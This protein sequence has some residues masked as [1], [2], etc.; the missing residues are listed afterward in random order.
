MSKLTDMLQDRFK[1]VKQAQAIQTKIESEKREWTA[2][3]RS[4]YDK[5]FADV[6]GMKDKIDELQKDEERGKKV[7]KA[8]E[9]MEKPLKKGIVEDI[10]VED[11]KLGPYDTPEYRKFFSKYLVTGPEAR[12]EFRGLQMDLDAGGGY[13]VLPQQFVGELIEATKALCFFR[14]IAKIY[15]VT[16][17]ESLGLP[18]LVARP[19]APTWTSELSIGAFDTAM[20][21]GKREL[22]P[23]PLAQGVKISKKLLR[24][25]T[26]NTD[27]TVRDQLAYMCAITEENAFLNGNGAGQPLGVFVANSEGIDTNRD[28]ST[29]NTATAIT[30]DGLINCYFNL[31]PVYWAQAKWIFH[32]NAIRNLRKLRGNDGDYLW[33]AGLSNDRGDTLL[34]CPVLISEFAPSTFT[35]GKYVGI[36]GDFSRYV[37]A[38]ALDVTLQV[39]TELYAGSNENGYLLRKE[40]DGMPVIAEAFSR[41]TLA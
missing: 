19:S 5:I 13:T 12:S 41:L 23:H 15:T 32:P 28:I 1:L 18:A 37:I 6:D 21:Y 17:A 14:S 8:L 22:H 29:D 40:T 10:G 20:Q 33:K 4:Q 39:L 30:S 9:E 38:D 31:R 26:L 11:R 25:S 34:N 16:N 2:E 3:E 27:Q 36:L 35:T 7:T 24:T